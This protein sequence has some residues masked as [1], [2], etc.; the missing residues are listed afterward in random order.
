MLVVFLVV[1]IWILLFNMGYAGARLQ[2]AQSVARLATFETLA[3][4]TTG[5]DAATQS[6]E[7]AD[8]VRER[9]FPK[10]QSGVEVSIYQPGVGDAMGGENE[11]FLDLL[12]GMVGALSGNTEVT[13]TVARK[14]PFQEFADTPIT[15]PIVVSGTPYTYCELDNA[16]FN[17]LE[18]E[19][20]AL[21]IL[22]VITGSANYI[23]APF[24]GLPLGSD[25]C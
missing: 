13:V 7:I 11:G 12:G 9:M 24:G 25:K 2:D 3:I 10:E 22:L 4:E 14:S 20:V 16:E 21:G 18:G 15:V 17:P 19:N 8:R 1:P 23:M 5:E 6:N